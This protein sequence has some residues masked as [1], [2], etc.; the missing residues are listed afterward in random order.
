MRREKVTRIQHNDYTI[1]HED[2]GSTL[3]ARTLVTNSKMRIKGRIKRARNFLERIA[4][5]GLLLVAV[6]WGWIM[7]T[8]G[9][10]FYHD[11]Y[12]KP[13]VKDSKSV[14]LSVEQ[15]SRSSPSSLIQP[16]ES[17]LLIFT[18]KRDN[19]LRETLTYIAKYIPSDCSIGCP[20][21]ISQD[22]KDQKVTSV[23]EEFQSKFTQQQIPVVHF[24]H[25]SALRGNA[26][27]YQALAVHYG[28]ALSQ[29]FDD[30]AKVPGQAAIIS[31]K[32]VVILEED[33]QIAP[34]FFAY[35]KY[36]APIL[37]KDSTLLAVSAFNDN[38]YDQKVKDPK[39]VL[40]SDFFPGLGWMMT[41]KLWDN[42]LKVK[43]PRGY[44]DD[45]L[46]DPAQRQDRQVLRPEISRTYH[47][48][49]KGGA[50]ANQFGGLLTK[51]K[52]D[53]DIV[54]WSQQDASALLPDQFDRHYWNLLH[55]ARQ[56]ASFEQALDACKSGN[57]I[58]EYRSFPDFQSL[59]LKLQIMDDEKAGIPRTAYKGV[60]EIRPH[61]E[62]ILFL[63]P[64]FRELKQ[65][66]AH[67]Q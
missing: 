31:P 55:S 44:W 33:L 16:Y 59:A 63:T 22:G 64:P 10:L 42:E 57:V 30:K 49:V 13:I 61:G 2:C 25:T 28:W 23:I 29:L 36:T 9:M 7:I 65:S 1:D 58:L 8:V 27:A 14:A 34:D 6:V 32:R 60:V 66:F 40:R 37:D 26:N 4:M 24:K 45:W 50:S 39:R 38:G 5:Y 21:V 3:Y 19:Y 15:V 17:P 35:F 11:Y 51:I 48:G 54:D 46:R 18:C 52:L 47:F 62:H 20:I 67:V 56:V 12:Q 53:T 41:R 43:W